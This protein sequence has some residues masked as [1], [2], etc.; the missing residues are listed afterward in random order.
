[1]DKSPAFTDEQK[2]M[3]DV[4][5]A[6][7]YVREIGGGGNVKATIGTAYELLAKLFPYRNDPRKQWTERRVRSFWHKEAAH[8]EFREMLELHRAAEVAKANRAK[9]SRA[10]KDHAAFIEQTARYRALLE[11]RTADEDCDLAAR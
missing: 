1:M 5:M 9:L 11:R 3:H 2:H 7:S 10:R 8:V 4:A 6:R